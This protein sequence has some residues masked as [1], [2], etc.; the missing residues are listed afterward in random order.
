MNSNTTLNAPSE[1][2]GTNATTINFTLN[3]AAMI[4]IVSGS[5]MADR[6][7]ISSVNFSDRLFY[8]MPVFI[9]IPQ[10]LLNSF[11]IISILLV[12]FGQNNSSRTRNPKFPSGSVSR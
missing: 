7:V 10:L 8:S 11:V 6:N 2:G 12:V 1:G 5:E 3:V 4:D 9:G